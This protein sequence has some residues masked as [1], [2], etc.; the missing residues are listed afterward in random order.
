MDK[1]SSNNID[2]K[3]SKRGKKVSEKDKESNE[4]VVYPS[5]R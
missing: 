2:K 3:V 4:L 5:F 1:C